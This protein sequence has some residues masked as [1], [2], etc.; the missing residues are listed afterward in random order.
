VLSVRWDGLFAYM[1]FARRSVLGDGVAY[2]VKHLS[3]AVVIDMATL[4]GAQGIATGRRTAALY[5][6]DA[7]LEAMAVA[8]GRAT[9]DLAHPLPYLPEVFQAEFA[10]PVADMKNSVKDRSNAGSAC[11]GQF[12]GSHLG[13][14]VDEG[15]WLHVDMAYP[16]FVGERGTGYGVALLWELLRGM[17]A[18]AVDTAAAPSA[19]AS[20]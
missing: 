9:G 3:P 12:V 4:T 7:E 18:F 11:A 10:S 14:F 1:R 16:A 6:N 8:A 19:G 20:D 2:A 5:C 17:P 15:R 13:T